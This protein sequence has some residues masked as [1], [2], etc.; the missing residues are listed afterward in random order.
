MA[1]VKTANNCDQVTYG[2]LH[3]EEQAPEQDNRHRAQQG[4]KH[5]ANCHAEQD[6][7][8]AIGRHDI[9]SQVTLFL[10]PVKLARHAPHDVH[11]ESCHCAADDHKADI[12]LRRVDGAV[13]EHIRGD[14]QHRQKDI[15]EHPRF[16]ALLPN[17]TRVGAGEDGLEKQP[18]AGGLL[19]L[20]SGKGINL[21]H[22]NL[23][24]PLHP[25]CD[26]RD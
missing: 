26:P 9:Q 2:V 22:S 17:N 18:P 15:K 12:F 24:S 4:G 8:H 25:C 6:R 19:H 13:Y 14:R 23:R 1:A 7:H 3:V 5:A 21:R 11:P 10:L 16:F 20:Q